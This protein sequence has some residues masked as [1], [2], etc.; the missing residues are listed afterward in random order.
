MEQPPL[1]SVDAVRDA[2]ARRLYRRSLVNGQI[3][4]PAVPG[5]IDENV[6]MCE[7]LFAGEGRAFTVEQLGQVRKVPE[8]QLAEAYA[9]SPRSN[10]V[11]S[12]D[13][14]FGTMLNYHV[15]AEWWSVE[16]A[17]ENWISTREPPLFGTEPDA[18][19]WT[20]AT[21]AANA[22]THPVLD[23]GGNGP[24]HPGLCAAWPPGRC[25]GVD[26]EVRRH[27]PRRGRTRVTQ[28]AR[29]QPR[30]LLHRR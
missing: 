11:L 2:L 30:R 22:T 23:I 19:V 5:M 17:Y 28:C 21:E 7:T 8:G 4:L 10:I 16:G 20:L 13:A 25:S 18:R 27:H 12:F 9:N 24:Q 14:P 1:R 3:T 15:K 6:S 26:P 29:D